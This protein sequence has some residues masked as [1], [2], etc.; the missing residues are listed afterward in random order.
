[1][2]RKLILAS[3][4]SMILVGTE[5]YALGVGV[6][7]TRSALNQPFLGQIELTDVRPDEL[8]AVKVSIA[9]SDAYAKAGLERYYYLTKLQFTPEV[10]PQGKTL[11][12]VSSREP[13]REPYMDLLVEVVWPQGQLIKQYTLL[14]DPP[15]LASRRT[16]GSG[17]ASGARQGA[18]GGS[19]GEGFPLEVG[20]VG[21]GTGL[22]ALAR[23]HRPEGA[24]VAQT[25]MA[26]YRSNQ[27]AFVRG[28]IHR[29][30]AG[31][32]L[33]LPSRDELFALDSAAAQREYSAAVKGRA[34]RRS[35]V[36]DVA[37]HTASAHLRI[38]GP[39]PAA[40]GLA[41]GSSSLAGSAV[42][43]SGPGMEKDVLLA[44][45]TSESTRQETQIL[46]DRIKELE[47]RLTDIQ[48]LLQVRS[49]E[50]ARMQAGASTPGL[51][52]EASTTTPEA[53][54]STPV[55]MS[56]E[57]SAAEETAPVTPADPPLEQLVAP[58][59]SPPSG[60]A[61]PPPVEA[62]PP[63]AEAAPAGLNAPVETLSPGFVP[64]P[65]PSAAPVE[66]SAPKPPARPAPPPAASAAAP[67]PSSDWDSLLLPLAGF[68]GL[69]AV[70]ILLF[71]WL[72]A[73]RRQREE[74]D[75]F[76]DID[77]LE[78]DEPAEPS[79]V[80]HLDDRKAEARTRESE[81]PTAKQGSDQ[82][83]QSTTN[84]KAGADGLASPM[85]MLSSLSN[86][87]AE[88]DEADVLSEADIYLAYGRHSEAEELLRNE[89]KRAPG[90]LDVKFK[91]AEA[92][93]GSK[94]L[95]AMAELMRDIEAAGGGQ[96]DPGQWR[97]L[98]ELYGRLGSGAEAG[99][100]GVTPPKGA[101]ASVP[102]PA[103]RDTRT[104]S[105]A[106]NLLVDSMGLGV[107]DV[108]SLD[109]SEEH[110]TSSGPA[111]REQGVTLGKPGSGG[112][113]LIDLDEDSR[114]GAGGT[115]AGFPDIDSGRDSYGEAV[116][117]PS[118][119][120]DRLPP[121]RGP[122]DDVPDHFRAGDSELIL[123]MEEQKVDMVDDLDSIFDTSSPEEDLT[124]VRDEMLAGRPLGL[125]QPALEIPDSVPDSLQPS[126]GESVPTDLLSSQWQM[127]SG[128]WDET[129]TKLD[130]AR[131]Y[132]EM[133]DVQAAREILQ[134]VMAEGRDEQRDEARSLLEKMA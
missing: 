79:T 118:A 87:D 131:A 92:Y 74:A 55:E 56:P 71:S 3:T 63:Q 95:D 115:I 109:L 67:E 54:A 122:L 24:T 6:L 43:A 64:V 72:T 124:L 128:I 75:R 40:D 98:Q 14:M 18:G 2:S 36:T 94:N 76:S 108:F 111:G 91:L 65:E 121:V 16:T 62:A 133:D 113:L 29:L 96:A 58:E 102:L 61:A 21:S 23:A 130:L 28:N 69:T 10:S 82:A 7:H 105:V 127:D 1:M 46:R 100:A 66:A 32:T 125:D 101:A 49:A 34:V 52:A 38:A 57:P 13:I 12:H 11:V 110:G 103:L 45:E 39:R 112:D 132:I 30:I 134:E 5:A 104:S 25:A 44:L 60:E 50:L 117:I 81:P 19:P 68:A 119:D 114:D 22:L 78:I 9:S 84:S 89:M 26:L 107:D 106:G 83:L 31:K 93:A 15:S 120:R 48:G 35:P 123:A 73:R 126:A 27:H 59:Q 41:G 8:D 4:M 99:E 51:L 80:P 86:F 90:R 97:R 37:S 20:P 53:L 85:S 129:A 70:G 77:S 33:I 88:T 116:T 42:R 17:S 47:T